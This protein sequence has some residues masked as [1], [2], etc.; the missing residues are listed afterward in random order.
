MGQ[1]KMHDSQRQQSANKPHINDPKAGLSKRETA[2]PSSS[3]LR[4]QKSNDDIRR[5]I[6]S[7]IDGAD[8]TVTS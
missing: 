1:R 8:Y 3:N 6:A 2:G 7:H 5:V 4:T